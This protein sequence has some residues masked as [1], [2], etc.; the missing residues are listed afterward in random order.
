MSSR[1]VTLIA[2]LLIPFL[3]AAS[4]Q[5]CSGSEV[6][7]AAKTESRAMLAQAE[8]ARSS[9][10]HLQGCPATKTGT[11]MKKCCGRCRMCPTDRHLPAPKPIPVATPTGRDSPIRLQARVIGIVDPLPGPTADF[12]FGLADTRVLMRHYGRIH[13]VICVL[14]L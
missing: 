1:L 13:A 14:R 6:R 3:G 5:A 7:S 10:E 12:G 8:T 2:F 9:Q 11:S 4:A